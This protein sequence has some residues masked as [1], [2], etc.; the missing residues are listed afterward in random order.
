[1]QWYPLEALE[2]VDISTCAGYAHSQGRPCCNRLSSAKRDAAKI[3]LEQMSH[4]SISSNEAI[5]RHLESLARNL[6]CAQWHENQAGPIVETWKR[7]VLSSQRAVMLRA[8]RDLE[9]SVDDITS[10][11]AL[12]SL[13]VPH[14]VPSNDSSGTRSLAEDRIVQPQRY[15]HVRP[16]FPNTSSTPY[17]ASVPLHGSGSS[18]MQSANE[19]NFLRSQYQV[20][21]V[22]QGASSSS[23]RSTP[24]S[25]TTTR[26]TQANE[27]LSQN[28]KTIQPDCP[29]CLDELECKHNVSRY[30]GC[31][32]KFHPSCIKAWVEQCKEMS[33]DATC[34]CW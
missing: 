33:A 7:R 20:A 30:H 11:L 1:M 31:L 34:P 16:V 15:Q 2:I 28:S 4:Y 19:H 29:I 32:E 22:Y 12:S 9:R 27:D 14:A 23:E 13:T 18:N 6:L 3:L 25:S 24:L 5:N 17:L 8:I 26:R 10:Q 21:E